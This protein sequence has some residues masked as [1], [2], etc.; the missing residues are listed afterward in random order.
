MRYRSWD[1]HIRK[2]AAIAMT[3]GLLFSVYIGSTN[4]TPSVA[5]FQPAA[6]EAWQEE[7]WEIF[8]TKMA[9]AAELRLETLPIRNIIV[10]L[11]L[12]FQGTPYAG[13]T[14]ENDNGEERLVINFRE[15][16]CVTFIE[17]ILAMARLIKDD[18]YSGTI[19]PGKAKKLYE[20]ILRNIRYRDG[21]ID[22]YP[23]R[24][25][26][27]TD[28]VLSNADSGNVMD[29]TESLG[30][31]RIDNPINFMS[32][33]PGVYPRLSVPDNLMQIQR[34]EAAVSTAV[35]HVIPQEDIA[36]IEHKIRDGDIVAM[37]TPVEGLDVVHTGIAI[38]RDGQ[39]HLLHAPFA[40]RPVEVSHRTLFE[41]TLSIRSHSGITVARP[42]D[43]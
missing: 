37:A 34:D 13:H 12:S 11:G 33:N 31:Q 20:Q 24:L 4:A 42:L 28:W 10:Q 22:G 40:G 36:L 5:T 1:R 19:D 38:W 26:Y 14:L 30:G 18:R 23:S 35:R 27:F 7:D 32:R 9:W 6:S 17:N 29:I 2:F 15:F 25:H 39:L 3:V 8:K 43:K 21:S 16:D 41:R